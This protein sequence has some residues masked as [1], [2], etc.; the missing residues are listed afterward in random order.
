MLLLISTTTSAYALLTPSVNVTVNVF[1]P[2]SPYY[3]DYYGVNASKVA[4]TVQ[5]LTGRVL[6]IKLAGQLTGK[7]NNVRLATYTNYVPLQAII[8]AP[9]EIKQ[10]NG[11][12]LKN[13]FDVNAISVT[14]IDKAKLAVSSRLPEGDYD[15]CLQAVDYANPQNVLSS[16]AASCSPI[17]I[18]YPEA[19]QLAAPANASTV[20]ATN[21]QSIIFNWFNANLVPVGTV[22][23]ITMAE[24]PDIAVNPTQVLN[25]TALPLL[26]QNV[27]GLSY[28]Y[29]V[30]NLQLKPGKRY[31]WRVTASDPSGK[32]IFKNNGV[33]AA[34][35]FTYGENKPSPTT[36]NGQIANNLNVVSPSCGIKN[37]TVIIGQHSDLK[38]AWLWRE[39]IESIKKF[40]TLDAQLVNH[41]T[42]M[43]TANGMVKIQRY[44]IDFL[45]VTDFGKIKK[46]HP[47]ITFT[48]NAPVQNFSLS[49]AD[50]VAKGFVTGEKYQVTVTAYDNNLNVLDKTTSCEWML[51]DEGA[52]RTPQLNISGRLAYT[53]D[54]SRYFGANN[55][56]ITLQ[57]VNSSTVKTIDQ[58][59]Q[60]VS[61]TTDDAGNF[62]AKL[63]LSA[64]DT[65]RKNVLVRINSPYYKP[66]D[67][68]GTYV[69]PSL[70]YVT[71][72]NKVMP[73]QDTLRLGD[74]N[75]QAYTNKL[76]V[77]LTKGFP[78]KISEADYKNVFGTTSDFN[79]DIPVD[80]FTVDPLGRIPDGT[81]VILFRKKKSNNIPYFETDAKRRPLDKNGY[82]V[83][84]DEVTQGGAAGNSNVVFTN[85]LC[86]FYEGDEYYVKAIIPDTGSN[87]KEQLAGPEVLYRFNPEVK[88][89]DLSFNSNLAYN[90][91][92]QKPPVSHVRGKVMYQWPSLPGVLHPYANQEVYIK[93]GVD[94]NTNT[95]PCSVVKWT[96]TFTGYKGKPMTLPWEPAQQQEHII[97]GQGVTDANGNFD[98]E[99]FTPY[100]MGV[101]D[102]VK[103]TPTGENG[104][105][106][107]KTPVDNNGDDPARKQTDGYKK[108]D[109][110]GKGGPVEQGG[111]GV[112]IGVSFSELAKTPADIPVNSGLVQLDKDAGQSVGAAD[113]PA[114]KGVSKGPSADT[115][116]QPEAIIAGDP[117]S[118]VERFF[119]IDIPKIKTSKYGSPVISDHFVVQPF[120][121]TDLGVIKSDVFELTDTRVHL[122][123]LGVNPK[124]DNAVADAAML[125]QNAKMVIY[126]RSDA[127]KLEFMPDGEGSFTHPKKPL[128]SPVFAK[129]PNA[130]K[131]EWVIDTTFTFNQY[132]MASLAKQRM[133]IDP[134]Q[135]QIQVSPSPEG[136]EGYFFPVSVPL[137]KIPNGA[138]YEMRKPIEVSIVSSFSRISGRLMNNGVSPIPNAKV[139]MSVLFGPKIDLVTD[140]NGYFEYSDFQSNDFF[141]TDG[142]YVTLLADVPGYTQVSYANGTLKAVGHNYYYE[143]KMKPNKVLMFKT[144][145]AYTNANVPG[146]VTGGDSTIKNNN[147]FLQAYFVPVPDKGDHLLTI[148][149][150][151]PAYFEE[152]YTQHD[153]DNVP[154]IKMYKRHHRMQFHLHVPFTDID[155]TTFKILINNKQYLPVYD[156]PNKTISFDFE[157][158]SVNNYTIQILDQAKQGYIPQIFNLTNDES[159]LPVVYEVEIGYG[160]TISGYVKLDGNAV[161]NARVYIDYNGEYVSDYDPTKKGGTVSNAALEART[162]NNGYYTIS[163]VPIAAG[164]NQVEM[165]ATIDNKV[166][167]GVTQFFTYDNKGRKDANFDLS[168]F[169]NAPD[170]K[171]IWGFPI[172]IERAKPVAVN[173]YLVDGIVDLGTNNNSPF[174][175]IGGTTKIRVT[176]VLY[177]LKNGKY[178][179]QLDNVPLNGYANL[180]LNYLDRYNVKLESAN[181]YKGQSVSLALVPTGTGGAIK[182]NVSIT[183][184]SFNFPSSYLSFEDKDTKLPIPFYLYD[185]SAGNRP[186]IMPQIPAIFNTAATNINYYLSDAALDSLSFSFIGFEK[187]KADPANSYID[188]KTKQIHLDVTVKGKVPHSDQGFVRVHIKDLVLDGD[189]IR[190]SQGT[191]PLVVNLQSWQLIVNKWSV[192]PHF[193]GIISHTGMIKTGVIDVPVG[194]FNLRGDLCVID[195]FKVKNL[196]LGGI[197]NLT[198]VQEQYTHLLWDAAC[199][200]DHSGHWRLSAA[201]PDKSPAATIPIPEIPGKIGATNLNVDYFQLVSFNNENLVSLSPSSGMKLYNNNKFTFNPKSV[202]SANGSFSLTGDANIDV[203]RLGT[204]PLSLLYTA[205][206]DGTLKMDAGSFDPIK[207]EGLGYVQFTSDKG[208]KFIASPEK[209]YVTTI[210]GTVVEP[211]KF[212]PIPCVLSF[213][214]SVGANGTDGPGDP[215]LGK[216]VLNQGYKLNMD[217]DGPATDDNVSITIGDE[218]KNN[219][220]VDNVTKDWTTLE[221]YGQM[222]DPKSNSVAKGGAPMSSTPSYYDFQVLGALQINTK[223][224]KMDKISTPLGDLDLAYDFATKELHGD[225]K[226]NNVKFGTYE[227]TGDMQMNMGPPGMQIFGNGSL[228]TGKLFVDGFGIINIGVIFGNRPIDAATE[229]TVLKYSTA[230]NNKCWLDDN[231]SDF[232]GFFLTGGLEVLHETDAANFAIA[233]VYFEATVA[234][235]ASVGAN[236]SKGNYMALLGAHAQVDAGMLSMTGTTVKGG[237]KA[238]LTAEATYSP[239]GFAINGD[240]GVTITITIGQYIPFLGTKTVTTT[241]GAK[242]LF[243][244][245]GGQPTHM[246]FSLD[247]DGNTVSCAEITPT[248]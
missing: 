220:H 194:L 209:N 212:N 237:L 50:A 71:S 136:N 70:R 172:A 191:E 188:R 81:H 54:K 240:A 223:G 222:N 236:F 207:F 114:A 15:L 185:K 36:D 243:G 124:D 105:K 7:G 246:D 92:S 139:K 200:S 181:T 16:N 75:T 41:Y 51:L 48:T 76:T 192:D 146:Y 168:T 158:I 205:N 203:P 108:V 43:A 208:A 235:E 115:G 3:S 187:T 174:K 17:S 225:L 73:L 74:V 12:A 164:Y 195:S 28:F 93:L 14:G 40:D 9:F 198:N 204:S 175:M 45:R 157:N 140:A 150:V 160:A 4:I 77:H 27:S 106:Q 122:N 166:V 226:M 224:M 179:P 152:T 217:G 162:D 107:T 38:V 91:I 227:F 133:V 184:N 127:P 155:V 130:Q 83:V 189:S 2:Y 118:S 102:G 245:G 25:A 109:V 149:P 221:F 142:Q 47:V 123:V 11:T 213:G 215:N 44:K 29:N 67:N 125:V 137:P 117:G 23:N 39:Q 34:S 24:M 59:K 176:A 143:I 87:I 111:G 186:K 5:N 49:Q 121:T 239:N 33:S 30:L 37:P 90:I 193:G 66:L 199:G 247:D 21:P 141:W 171:D 173:Q 22:Y 64:S 230:K 35:Y 165:H 104:C 32:T 154:L 116:E 8:L 62:T 177:G 94:Y 202:T 119:Y 6:K 229:N 60:Y 79:L 234:V 72:N 80:N 101:I 211:G 46:E 241:K 131:V 132:Q 218:D 57:I 103:A 56:S 113:I 242:A 153:A 210:A 88:P 182:G 26:S 170:I 85:M 190:T 159:R 55:T 238:H 231:K 89:T 144:K 135:Y 10:L 148:Y 96:Q 128:I 156:K 167:S 65:G 138:Y 206:N 180:K 244:Y 196:A 216:I 112:Q 147:N 197:L 19:P 98:I 78:K 84:A 163:G 169:A 31:A 214:A 100:K 233:S 63:T 161:S 248:P 183:D 53:L 201:T 58:A 68:N 110:L 69:I 86:N 18:I 99:V 120:Q 42:Q 61:V 126:R 228:N 97:M 82:I 20:S 134:D 1:P 13:I 145:D 95:D 151:D 178:E 129:D 52:E 219:M 232:K